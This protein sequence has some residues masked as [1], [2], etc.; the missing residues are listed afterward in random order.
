[1]TVHVLSGAKIHK[2][3]ERTRTFCKHIQDAISVSYD[4]TVQCIRKV[5]KT[6]SPFQHFVTLQ[7][8]SEM[9]L[10]NVKIL[11]NLQTIPNNDEGKTGL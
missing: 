2:R 1:M 9:D 10:K 4:S 5:G 6:P 7:P 11:S 3:K 8:Y